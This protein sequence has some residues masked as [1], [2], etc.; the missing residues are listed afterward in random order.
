MSKKEFA[1][2][3]FRISKV[4]RSCLGPLCMGREPFLSVGPENRV[5]PKCQMAIDRMGR[6]YV[7]PMRTEAVLDS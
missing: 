7:R 2:K 5:C 6:L 1:K 4:M 3:R